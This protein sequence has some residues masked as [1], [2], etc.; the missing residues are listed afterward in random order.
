MARR[1]FGP[2][3]AAVAALLTI[4]GLASIVG[5]IGAQP[6]PGARAAQA[7]QAP[8][9]VEGYRSARFGMAEAEVRKMMAKDFGVKGDKIER[10]TH[11]IEKT[12]SMAF[13]SGEI[14]PEAGPVRVAYVFGYE[15][16]RLIQVTVGWGQ[17]ANPD[18]KLEGIVAAAN[19]LRRYFTGRGFPADSV[20]TNRRAE[21]GSVIVFQGADDKGRTVFLKLKV[22]REAGTEAEGAAPRSGATWLRLS[23]IE[24]PSDP[25]IFRVKTGDF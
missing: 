6:P 1:K 21:D 17:P 4:G 16:K 15:S 7:Q 24:N 18:P 2:A 8:A 14:I 20:I 5:V 9:T 25:D 10:S 22:P 19:I 3:V 11:P 12:T 23:Y 13:T